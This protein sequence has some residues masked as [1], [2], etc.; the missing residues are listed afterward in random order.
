MRLVINIPPFSGKW[1][2]LN[3]KK[4]FWPVELDMPIAEYEVKLA[5]VAALVESAPSDRFI[6]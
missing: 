4:G 3:I 2:A 6:R 5:C 1:P